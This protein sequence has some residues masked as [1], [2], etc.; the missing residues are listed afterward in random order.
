MPGGVELLRF[1][2]AVATGDRETLNAARIAVVEALG[3]EVMVDA[4]AVAAVFQMMNRVA[5]A[6]GTPLDDGIVDLTASVRKEL[7]LEYLSAKD[8]PGGD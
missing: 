3:A 6:T 5:N 8:Q 1:I 4:A 7:K 2:E